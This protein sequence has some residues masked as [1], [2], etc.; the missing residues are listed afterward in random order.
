PIKFSRGD[1]AKA[2]RFLA[3]R[4]PVGVRCLRN[5]SGPVIS[6][7]WG[8]GGDEHERALH[9]LADARFVGT[10]SDDAIVGEGDDGVAE[11]PDRMHH[12][13]SEQRLVYVS[14]QSPLAGG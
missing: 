3:Q 13:I 6:D 10:Y 4:R 5:L 8:K 7:L 1:E 9:Q 12:A 11:Q 14:V 2:N